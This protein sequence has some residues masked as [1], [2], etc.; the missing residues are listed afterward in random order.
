MVVEALK[1]RDNWSAARFYVA[2]SALRNMQAG[3]LGRCP[4]AVAFRTFGAE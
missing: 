1:A 3:Y 4:Q 2:P